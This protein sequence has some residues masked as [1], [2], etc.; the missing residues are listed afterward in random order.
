MAL[1]KGWEDHL[2]PWLVAKRD[3]S[4]PDPSVAKTQEKFYHQAVVASA[5][6]KV[7]A[8]ILLYVENQ[9]ATYEALTKKMSAEKI[10]KDK[11][12][13]GGTK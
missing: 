1:N 6:K 7:V 10:E 4:F 3:Q 5:F 11:Y 12:S 8:E 9:K 13:I 2:S